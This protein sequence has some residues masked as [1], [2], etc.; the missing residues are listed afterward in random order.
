LAHDDLVLKNKQSEAVISVLANDVVPIA[1]DFEHQTTLHAANDSG[2]TFSSIGGSPDKEY[3]W[4]R[5]INGFSVFETA[6]GS[7]STVVLEGFAFESDLGIISADCSDEEFIAMRWALWTGG[8]VIIQ[9]DF[10]TWTIEN[11]SF[12]AGVI[13]DHAHDFGW[14]VGAF[15]NADR[16]FFMR[17][18]GYDGLS[19]TITVEDAGYLTFTQ[20]PRLSLVSPPQ[21]GTAEP[22]GGM[23]RYLPDIDSEGIDTFSY[24]V[25]TQL[26]DT[27]TA[28]VAIGTMDLDIHDLGGS[29]LS[30]AEEDQPGLYLPVNSDDDD[31]NGLP[32]HLDSGF[33]DDELAR[34]VIKERAPAGM[35]PLEG[36]FILGFD[37]TRIRVW[38]RND[39]TQPA[40]FESAEV[41]SGQTRI[42]VTGTAA[43][44]ELWVE[45][46]AWGATNIQ[47][48]WHDQVLGAAAVFDAVRVTVVGV[49]LGIDADNDNGYEFPEGD[50]WEEHLKNHSHAIGK[51]IFEGAGRST[52]ILLTLPRGLDPG[53]PT[54]RVQLTYDPVNQYGGV[55]RLYNGPYEDENRDFLPSSSSVSSSGGYRLS[56]LNYDPITGLS[57]LW[58][59]SPFRDHSYG[60]KYLDLLN[61]SKPETRLRAT[62]ADSG[63]GE[64]DIFDEVKYLVEPFTLLSGVPPDGPNSLQSGPFF[65]TL[66]GLDS[67]S[68]Y[69]RIAVRNA[70][71]SSLVYGPHDGPEWS[72][73]MLTEEEVEE[74]LVE[75]GLDEDELDFVL[76]VLFE[77]P[78][79]DPIMPP[80]SGLKV[81]LYKDYAAP[82]PGQYVLAF[83][84]T[85]SNDLTDMLTNLH[86]LLVPEDPQYMVAQK[87]GAYLSPV[88]TDSL[89]VTGHSLGGGLASGAAFAGG[90]PAT[91]YNA[92]GLQRH[93]LCY[94]A[95]W[96]NESVCNEL[97]A[98]SL[99]RFDLES[100]SPGLLIQ[101]FRT[102]L[103]P[104]RR[105]GTVD[106]P[107]LLHWIQYAV[108]FLPQ[109]SG[110]LVNIEGLTNLNSGER[111]ILD[112]AF[113]ILRGLDFVEQWPALI[114]GALSAAN[115]FALPSKMLDSHGIKFSV[116]FG[117]LHDDQ[118]GWNA[119]ST[120]HPDV[121]PN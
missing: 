8:V 16:A 110:N 23:F 101:S 14:S 62:L 57:V 74:L 89:M 80:L 72:L 73:R 100:A 116:L 59:E 109:A 27:S 22:I 77:R 36:Y 11:V 6:D 29:E 50:Q 41:I 10:G 106:T 114:M 34:L 84:G 76:A 51:I 81:A 45:G 111:L 118:T 71:A 60:S 82:N 88:L 12:S 91:T 113:S 5:D 117:L 39:K 26:G 78:F 97:F 46:I 68:K 37:S 79:S 15:S 119:Y 55:F 2:F 47:L 94:S 38:H 121:G 13:I 93:T 7:F 17:L 40:G 32:D 21:H 98:G 56:D 115:I 3:Y 95:T 64:F 49:H 66:A 61:G 67:K 112:A 24:Q 92:A 28:T 52:P 25:M 99:E 30:E 96:I 65:P 104:V 108:P 70:L 120:A 102:W 20:P 87:L 90:I 48:A 69:G 42:H 1:Q 63:I 33:V 35:H 58:A 44:I 83:A 43:D 18:Y 85:E 9:S 31:G 19:S 107:D 53:H 4:Y 86:Q 105:N 103:S 54:F 75:R